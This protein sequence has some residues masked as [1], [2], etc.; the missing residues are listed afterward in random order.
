MISSLAQIHPKARIA[1]NVTID[2][3]CVIEADVEIGEGT[4]I[5][6]NVCVFNGSRIGK[7]CTIFPG[8]VIGAIPQDLKFKGEQTTA[9]IGDNT[10]LRECVTIH[11]GTQD[12]WTTKVGNNCLIMAYSHVAHDCNVGNNV[13]MANAV[14]LAGHVVIDDF[15]RIGGLTGVHQFIHLGAH[16]YIA[17]QIVIRKDV[18]PFVKAAR[19][20]ISYVGV[21]VVG[22]ERNG[23]TKEMIR[24]IHDIYH[25]VFVQG[26]STS[27][28]LEIIQAT[29]EDSP[30][31]DQIVSFIKNSTTGIIKRHKDATNDDY[32]F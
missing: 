9:V 10:T 29:S 23:Y 19:D 7:H 2:A 24:Q 32:A 1:D 8:A 14:Q 6:P 27:K 22:L 4:H 21:N 31:K 15:A 25:I 11:R 26:N 20:P 18:P 12:K 30:I 13:I 3:F 17:G 28:A 5:M 16:T